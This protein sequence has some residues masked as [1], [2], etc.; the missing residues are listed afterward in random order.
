MYGFCIAGWHFQRQVINSSSQSHVLSVWNCPLNVTLWKCCTDPGWQAL[1]YAN[2]HAHTQ[3]RSRPSQ[4]CLELGVST[5]TQ[6]K[7]S[8]QTWQIASVL[9]VRSNNKI[10]LLLPARQQ[11]PVDRNIWIPA[12][13]LCKYVW[14]R[15]WGWKWERS[16]TPSLL[17]QSIT[18]WF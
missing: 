2:T 16:L 10:L 12:L 8:F 6:M 13:A 11:Q 14:R 1:L 9:L 5:Q 4:P 17:F 3:D 15:E 7:K 18:L